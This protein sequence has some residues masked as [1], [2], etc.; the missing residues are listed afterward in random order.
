MS[1]STPS[2]EVYTTSMCPYCVMAKQLLDKKGVSY[3]EV[4]VDQDQDLMS[5]MM[6]RSKQRS[7]PQIFIND[8]HIGGFDD[9]SALDHKSGLDS[10]LGIGS[11]D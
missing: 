10:L 1:L 6:Q 7:V 2:I 8:L 3:S 5:E 4:Y 9:L 11:A